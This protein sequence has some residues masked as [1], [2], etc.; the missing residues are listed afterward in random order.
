MGLDG[1][2]T[3]GAV[4][5]LLR[6]KRFWLVAIAVVVVVI[7]LVVILTIV[8]PVS[9][10]RMAE[11]EIQAAITTLEAN[12]EPVPDHLTVSPQPG[13]VGTSGDFC[14]IIDYEVCQG[15][16]FLRWAS[17]ALTGC[18]RTFE[19]LTVDE[20]PVD[21]SQRSLLSL[22]TING[23]SASDMNACIKTPLEPGKHLLTVEAYPMRRRVR[24]S[25][26]WDVVP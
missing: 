1:G 25:W 10:A 20:D 6:N 16:P 13:Q 7:A 2:V 4:S 8:R 11:A 5:T 14:V 21:Y 15:D 23:K 9:P 17:S 24:Y 19:S 22:V 18:G 12:P 26:V 3:E